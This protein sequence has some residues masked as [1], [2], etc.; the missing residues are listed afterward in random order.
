M[1][2]AIRAFGQAV[3]EAQSMHQAGAAA[4]SLRVALSHANALLDALERKLGDARKRECDGESRRLII[5]MR[6]NLR[7]IEATLDPPRS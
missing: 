3:A 7:A 2:K 4:E 6:R 5:H 1:R